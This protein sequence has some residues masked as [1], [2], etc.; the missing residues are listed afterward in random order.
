MEGHFHSFH[1]SNHLI[2]KAFFCLA[3]AVLASISVAFAQADFEKS[4]PLK[5]TQSIDLQVEYGDLK[6]Q[7]WD[8]DRVFIKGKVIIN[9]GKNNDSY[10][11]EAKYKND[12]L[13]VSFDIPDIKNIPKMYWE[14]IDGKRVFYDTKEEIK[15]KK[16]YSSGV[17]TDGELEVF[18]PRKMATEVHSTYGNIAIENVSAPLEI[19]NTYGSVEAIFEKISPS[20][21]IKL[22]STYSF[23]DIHLPKSSDAQVDLE[24]DYG[25]IF[26]DMEL[27]VQD[28]DE[29]RF[30]TGRI[31]ANI[32]DGGGTLIAKATYNNVYLRAR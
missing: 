21:K 12:K 32:N 1:S 18:I 3:L 27:D 25:E 15:G 8:Q 6:I 7:S 5:N 4:I 17:Y 16:G 28:F 24:T 20:D 9:D 29:G 22:T 14:E 26:T 10:K 30:G 19:R 11:I 31:K 23:V 2:M 13:I